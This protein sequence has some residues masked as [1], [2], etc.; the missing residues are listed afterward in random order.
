MKKIVFKKLLGL[1]LTVF[2]VMFFN[3]TCATTLKKTDIEQLFSNQYTVGELN[4]NVP[5]WPLFLKS[6][7]DATTKPIL[8]GY[9][10]ESVDFE[11]VRGYGGKPINILVAIDTQ[12]NFLESKLISHRE[13]LFRSE[14]GIAKLTDFAA[15]YK[16]LSI[17]HDIQLYDHK[18][19]TS[20][21]DKNAALHG[22]QAGTVSV[23]AID[24]T[25][26]Q[27]ATSVAR[28]HQEAAKTGNIVGAGN[29]IALTK[30]KLYEAQVRPLQ[31]A[32]L[33]WRGMVQTSHITRGQI[34]KAFV[35][36]RAAGADKLAV[37][38]PDEI[39]LQ[40]HVAL[41][42]LPAIGRNILDDEGWRLVAANR[43]DSQALMVTETGPLAK[44]MYE[45]QR[46]VD[47]LP[48]VL[49]QDGKTIG[50]RSIAYDKGVKIP[51]YPTQT[52]AHFLIIDTATPLDPTQP[53]NLT[54]KLGRRFGSFPN[55]KAY[56]EF[57]LPYHFHGWRQQVSNYLDADWVG[58]WIK[59]S[60]EIA[61]VLIALTL[62]SI[63][64]IRQHTLTATTTRLTRF[65][66][67][68]LLFT[69]I[70]I[71]WVF[72]GQLSIVNII[73]AIESIA[74]GND[75]SFFLTDPI[76]V[77]LWI[78]V[79]FTLFIWGRGTFCGWLC[80][81]GA[82]QELVS[83]SIRFL[84]LRHK[85]IRPGID[86]KLK[87]IKYILLLSLLSMIF[88]SPSTTEIGVE[89]EPF[90]TAISL[91]FVRDWPYVLWAVTCLTLSVV[92]YRGYCRYICPLGAALAAF[93]PLRKWGWIARRSE[94][95]TPCQTCR[96]R[97]DYQ[98]I[99]QV[100]H[101]AYSECFQCM[102]CV[103]IYQDKKQCLPL[104]KE[105]KRQHI[106]IQIHAVTGNL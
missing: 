19:K 45:S 57:P 83:K 88:I 76:T 48:F 55:Q 47:D 77:I 87:W 22:V 15:Q 18:A 106:V 59:R 23:K 17:H 73:A 16:G 80:P 96:S 37:T 54:F 101:I 43:R 82:F 21:D 71:G 13:P 29:A 86:R 72:Q 51:G 50:L 12:G 25:I 81:F 90:K 103:S 75:L 20:R 11:P 74:A 35:G 78:F 42:S 95:G 98:A 7:P 69:L 84:G 89:V 104:V 44:M 56:V 30:G 40:F 68:F 24:R 5:V 1:L 39:A 27:S 62:L 100:G 102:D 64:L 36:T 33:E 60:G 31:L 79:G 2:S 70:G 52:R 91:Y 14:A 94:C 32:E 53:F 65:R 99:D 93:N 63:A 26:L 28:A 92:V 4:P 58:V 6:P 85:R 3:Q 10:F 8:F 67:G 61:A 97:C 41:V 46:I 66:V 34:E 49:K 105:I 9:A 38:S